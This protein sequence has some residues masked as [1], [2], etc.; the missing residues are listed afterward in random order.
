MAA[1]T[2]A[3]KNGKFSS[4]TGSHRSHPCSTSSVLLGILFV[5]RF[6]IKG[7]I[8]RTWILALVCP[9]SPMCSMALVEVLLSWPRGHTRVF[10]WRLLYVTVHIVQ[11]T[12]R[13]WNV[14]TPD[15]LCLLLHYGSTWVTIAG[16]N[17]AVWGFWTI[18][19]VECER[20][21]H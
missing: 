11:C 18:S 7:H 1:A 17:A 13:T 6:S 9:A 2:T 5:L 16:S 4:P 20:S 12:V 21:M 14:S 19:I 15:T 10:S 3:I 8:F